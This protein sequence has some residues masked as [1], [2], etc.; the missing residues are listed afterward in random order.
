MRG[1]VDVPVSGC[2]G[3]LGCFRTLSFGETED[4]RLAVRSGDGW[5]L[6]VEFRDVP[7]AYSVLGY[8]QS[9]LEESPHFA[10]QAEMFA[11]GELKY[12]AWTDEDIERKEIR[13]YR[14]GREAGR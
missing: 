9:A 10:D 4:G 11:R 7:R 3:G 1:D 5:I 12:V 2:E 13:R 6:A 8:G 14:P